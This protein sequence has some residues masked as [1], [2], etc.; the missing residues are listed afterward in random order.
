MQHFGPVMLWW[1]F[2]N[3][4]I[5]GKEIA[6]LRRRNEVE[7]HVEA[8]IL[9]GKL[10]RFLTGTITVAQQDLEC[11]Q[12]LKPDPLK[13]LH[14]RDNTRMNLMSELA[15][16]ILATRERTGTWLNLVKY[17]HGSAL[18][19]IDVRQP[20]PF[21][22]EAVR[23]KVPLLRSGDVMQCNVFVQAVLFG[24]RF[25]CVE[26]VPAASEVR[27]LTH[28]KKDWNA[29]VRA[30]FQAG[31][32]DGEEL[33]TFEEYDSWAV[34]SYY[35]EE[36]STEEKA[37]RRDLSMF[38]KYHLIP[39]VVGPVDTASPFPGWT[40]FAG[41]TTLMT[42]IFIRTRWWWRRRSRRGRSRDEA[43]ASIKCRRAASAPGA[44]RRRGGGGAQVMPILKNRNG[45]SP[46]DPAMNMAQ[47]PGPLMAPR[48][49]LFQVR[50]GRPKKSFGGSSRSGTTGVGCRAPLDPAWDREWK[51]NP[52]QQNDHLWYYGTVTT[53]P[54]KEDGLVALYCVVLA[55]PERK[56]RSGKG[57]YKVPWFQVV[58]EVMEMRVSK[59]IPTDFQ[60][61]GVTP[62]PEV[63]RA[64]D[65]SKSPEAN[66]KLVVDRVSIPELIKAWKTKSRIIMLFNIATYRR[67][68]TSFVHAN[69]PVEWDKNGRLNTRIA[70]FFPP[71]EKIYYK[72]EDRVWTDD[73]EEED[74]EAAAANE[75]SAWDKGKMCLL[76]NVPGWDFMYFV[77]Y[78]SPVPN[79]DLH[80]VQFLGNSGFACQRTP[81]QLPVLSR[82]FISRVDFREN[83]PVILF[84]SNREACQAYTAEIPGDVLRKNMQ[85]FEDGDLPLNSGG[86]SRRRKIL[87]TFGFLSHYPV[88]KNH[89]YKIFYP[90]S[91]K[92]FMKAMILN[93]GIKIKYLDFK[94]FKS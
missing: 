18:R 16:D 34:S 46:S 75:L 8:N 26:C 67:G 49:V 63:A 24:R 53:A 79:S 22:E 43:Q 59:E 80:L 65:G 23:Q 47:F 33:F 40:L 70:S 71:G 93:L 85:V 77:E 90:D 88:I 82:A 81:K 52:V 17:H 13:P 86:S 51:V 28:Y 11:L 6:G 58:V 54:D 37:K 73:E 38:V 55:A 35:S 66:H 76:P 72:A 89:D 56:Y 1:C 29:E 36:L 41:T 10:G 31:P 87:G 91:V 9:R 48:P 94:I 74:E 7:S 25:L 57:K 45:A 30:K 83:K 32:P 19:V 20:H 21:E 92:K 62:K 44:G 68:V 12:S 42:K 2:R 15:A 4:R 69:Q 14:D 61:R 27:G 3:E 5:I 39:K 50:C 84:V 60:V 64:W 78:I